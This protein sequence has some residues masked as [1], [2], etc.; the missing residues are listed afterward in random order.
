MPLRYYTDELTMYM[1]GPVM[2]ARTPQLYNGGEEYEYYYLH[3][4]VLG[5][6]HGAWFRGHCG[7]GSPMM[8]HL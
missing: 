8:A 2:V 7:A 1:G 6:F 4:L 5:F 3:Q